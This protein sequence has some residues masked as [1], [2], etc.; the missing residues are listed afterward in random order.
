MP[1]KPPR[2]PAYRK[3]WQIFHPA[4]AAY[5]IRG[6]S[7]A[8]LFAHAAQALVAT[9]TDR[10]RLR[11]RELREI[12]VTAPDR[13]S[14][15]VAWLNQLVYLYD[16]EGFLGRDFTVREINDESLKAQA[17]GDLFDPERHLGKTAVKAATYHHL[18]I[19]PRDHGW[20]ATV[21]LDI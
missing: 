11:R 18:E 7:L 3:Y 12:E 21:I 8:E 4:D 9:I 2:K 16:V 20:Q 1:A 13:E 19:K 15:L 10:R 14:L 17:R 5:H 6:E